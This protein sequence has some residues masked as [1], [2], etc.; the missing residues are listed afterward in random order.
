MLWTAGRPDGI[1]RR[2]DDWQGTEFSNLQ[3]VLNLLETLMNSGIPVKKHHY[4]EVILA[5]RM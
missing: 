3:T 2:P 1:T 4:N 5:N